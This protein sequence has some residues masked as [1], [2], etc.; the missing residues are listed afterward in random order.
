[1]SSICTIIHPVWANGPVF[2]HIDCND[3][4]SQ[5]HYE[6][7]KGILCPFLAALG[8]YYFSVTQLSLVGTSIF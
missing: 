6:V 3:L 4:M 7:I 8:E 2:E 1:M 5:R